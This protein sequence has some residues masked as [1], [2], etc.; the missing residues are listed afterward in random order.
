MPV[1][2]GAGLNILVRNMRNNILAALAALG[3]TVAAEPTKR[4]RLSFIRPPSPR[5]PY[6]GDYMVPYVRGGVRT[7]NT[8]RHHRRENAKEAYRQASRKEISQ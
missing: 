1:A 7:L 3:G 6:I 2:D 4:S 8:Y 5:R